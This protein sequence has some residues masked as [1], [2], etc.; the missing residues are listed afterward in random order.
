MSVLD[1]WNMWD[2]NE[3]MLCAIQSQLS[4]RP[5][6]ACICKLY[7]SLNCWLTGSIVCGLF[8]KQNAFAH[9]QSLG[10]HLEVRLQLARGEVPHCRHQVFVI[11]SHPAADGE[12]TGLT[13]QYGEK[14]SVKVKEYAT[15]PTKCK[16][17]NIAIHWQKAEKKIASWRMYTMQVEKFSKNS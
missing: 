9:P 3:S 8:Y 13:E 4:M 15:T 1:S 10:L 6:Y 7:V 2:H 17:K 16:K 12:M 14:D 5:M 11:K